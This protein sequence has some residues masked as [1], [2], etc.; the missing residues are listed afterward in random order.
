MQSAI[1]F[2]SEPAKFRLEARSSI[3][4]HRHQQDITR[5]LACLAHLG[6]RLEA[7]A[8]RS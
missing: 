1:W 5:N 2:D 7:A 8:D 4:R 3:R 6:I